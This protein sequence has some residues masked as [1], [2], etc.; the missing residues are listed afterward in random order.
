MKSQHQKGFRNCTARETVTVFPLAERENKSFFGS[1]KRFVKR[2]ERQNGTIRK[3]W[4]TDR[5]IFVRL[6]TQWRNKGY[7][8]TCHR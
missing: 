2:S 6:C 8:G 3:V 7:T 1:G 5:P 4:Q